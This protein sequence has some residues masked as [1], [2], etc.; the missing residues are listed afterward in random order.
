M[1]PPWLAVVVAERIDWL[2]PRPVVVRDSGRKGEDEDAWE[3]ATGEKGEK[4]DAVDAPGL[5]APDGD[6]VRSALDTFCG[7]SIGGMDAGY[8]AGSGASFVT[9]ESSCEVLSV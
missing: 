4:A 5:K 8:D 3:S 9:L 1:M 2:S 7:G 6:C